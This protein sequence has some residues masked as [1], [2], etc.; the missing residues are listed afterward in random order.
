M[1][2]DDQSAS[3]KGLRAGVQFALNVPFGIRNVSI[4]IVRGPHQQIEL[5]P[6]GSNTATTDFA[7]TDSEPLGGAISETTAP[8]AVDVDQLALVNDPVGPWRRHFAGTT[9][10][11]TA[12]VAGSSGK[13]ADAA[14]NAAVMVAACTS[15]PIKRPNPGGVVSTRCTP[16]DGHGAAQTE[17][18]SRTTTTALDASTSTTR[19]TQKA[20]HTAAG[21][22]MAVAQS[23][24]P[25]LPSSPVVVLA[26]RSQSNKRV[27]G[28][29]SSQEK[30]KRGPF[31]TGS[32]I[33]NKH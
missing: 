15:T 2:S 21:A 18:R 31:S 28:T 16:T 23:P 11:A 33:Q 6:S 8:L 19:R 3:Q 13:D 7:D 25:R 27:R 17:H 32:G 12:K 26:M 4:R 24:S 30:K 29:G 1:S 10:T 5:S 20:A 9:T 14:V 22:A